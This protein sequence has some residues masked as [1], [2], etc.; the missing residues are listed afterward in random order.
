MSKGQMKYELGKGLPNGQSVA[1]KNGVGVNVAV[2]YK[3]C[4]I[5]LRVNGHNGSLYNF[6]ATD[7]DAAKKVVQ[8][9]RSRFPESDIRYRVYGGD[10][11][12]K[13]A[14]PLENSRNG[15]SRESSSIRS[16]QEVIEIF[17]LPMEKTPRVEVSPQ[18]R[19]FE[20]RYDPWKSQI[21]KPQQF[22]NWWEY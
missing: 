8:S 13:G 2:G 7:K 4:Q 6:P 18:E 20:D 1:G 10:V 17:A 19:L 12:V 3:N 21:P 11:N 16:V 9:I 5:Y 15:Y 22:R 14:Y